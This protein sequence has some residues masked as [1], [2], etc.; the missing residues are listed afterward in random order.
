MLEVVNNIWCKETSCK[1]PLLL[2]MEIHWAMFNIRA[3][4]REQSEVFSTRSCEAWYYIAQIF[5]LLNHILRLV[6]IKVFK[7]KPGYICKQIIT[8]INT[9]KFV[10]HNS[11]H[12]LMTYNDLR[13]RNGLTTILFWLCSLQDNV[14]LPS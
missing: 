3:Q 9:Y 2:I 10:D 8:Y 4:T 13:K 14:Y 5:Y 12:Y 6:Y 1:K 11:L 7:I